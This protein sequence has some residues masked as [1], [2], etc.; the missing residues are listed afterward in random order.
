MSGALGGPSTIFNKQLE[1]NGGRKCR[2]VS[3]AMGGPWPQPGSRLFS[4]FGRPCY[5]AATV[6]ERV[7]PRDEFQLKGTFYRVSA[8]YPY[9]TV[10]PLLPL[11]FIMHVGTVRAGARAVLA[12]ALIA[13][14][15][16]SAFWFTI[17]C[18]SHHKH[19]FSL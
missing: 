10:S 4:P 11:Q 1:Y 16:G 18:A 19:N 12:D 15:D 6:P 13:L 14:A 2:A 7:R 9:L 5:I 3:S 8:C 17:N